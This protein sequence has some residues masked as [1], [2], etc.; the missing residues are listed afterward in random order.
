MKVICNH[1]KDCPNKGCMHFKEH[2]PIEGMDKEK[3]GNCYQVL[4]YC[5][6]VKADVICEEK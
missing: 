2:S 6:I 5:P 1:S 4:T 3:P